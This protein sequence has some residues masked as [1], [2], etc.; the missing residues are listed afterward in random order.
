MEG[1]KGPQ[2]NYTNRFLIGKIHLA[3]FIYF[4]SKNIEKMSTLF[5]GG[6]HHKY[7]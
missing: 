2:Y 1:T 4:M 7:V 5:Y 3:P 6:S